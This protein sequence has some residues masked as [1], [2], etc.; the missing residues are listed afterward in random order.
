MYSRLKCAPSV[1]LQLTVRSYI[2]K[3]SYSV[4]LPWRTH[5]CTQEA[6]VRRGMEWNEKD[7]R[8]LSEPLHLWSA[9]GGCWTLRSFWESV[10]SSAACGSV[11]SSSSV[12]LRRCQYSCFQPP[13]LALNAS[14]GE[15]WGSTQRKPLHT[16]ISLIYPAGLPKQCFFSGG[17]PDLWPFATMRHCLGVPV[18]VSVNLLMQRDV[19]QGSLPFSSVWV[20]NERLGLRRCFSCRANRGLRVT[21]SLGKTSTVCKKKQETALKN[22]PQ[23]YNVPGTIT[24]FKTWEEWY[25]MFNNV[26]AIFKS[27]RAAELRV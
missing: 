23:C 6:W 9:T 12:L 11:S 5:T 14:S 10:W 4:S 2:N 25:R 8:D 22:P 21:Y 27:G 16:H 13:G 1:V 19:S 17:P 26:W 24:G 3:V 20:K 15:D 18:D 7:G